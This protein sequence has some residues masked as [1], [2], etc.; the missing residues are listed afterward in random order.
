MRRVDT[1]AH[2]GGVDALEGDLLWEFGLQREFLLIR[3]ELCVGSQPALDP[4]EEL[5]AGDIGPDGEL[6]VEVGGLQRLQTRSVDGG[7]S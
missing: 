1:L 7:L 4:L 3:N 6:L 5:F 2:E